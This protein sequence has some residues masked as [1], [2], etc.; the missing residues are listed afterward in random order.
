MTLWQRFVEVNRPGPPEDSISFRAAS[1]AAVL[2]GIGACWSEGELSPTVSL[3]AVVATVVGN[4]VA[5]RRR[6]D[7]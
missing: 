2:L 3:F 7:P 6:A 4:I 5:Y 1:V